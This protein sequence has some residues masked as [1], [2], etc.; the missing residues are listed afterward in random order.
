LGKGQFVFDT[1]VRPFFRKLEYQDSGEALRYW[2]MNP[3]GRIVLDPHRSFGR[4]IDAATG[5]P[6]RALYDA[7]MAGSGQSPEVVAEWFG[8]PLEA[9]Q[10]AVTFESS[11]RNR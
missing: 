8:I 10:A 1:A 6:T 4:P 2:P 7:V 3:E 11:L 9:V 5:I